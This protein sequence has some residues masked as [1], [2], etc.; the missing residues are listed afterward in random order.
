[1]ES[2]SLTGLLPALPRSLIDRPADSYTLGIPNKE[3]RVGLMDNMLP[4]FSR[5]GAAENSTM[6][7]F[8]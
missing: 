4:V 8:Q 5:K 1:M 7:Y 3:V 6:W 2:S